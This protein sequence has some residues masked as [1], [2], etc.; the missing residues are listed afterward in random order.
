MIGHPQTRL[1][2]FSISSGVIVERANNARAVELPHDSPEAQSKGNLYL[3]IKLTD[4]ESGHARLY[5]QMLAATQATYYT[6]KGSIEASLVHAI[7]AADVAL[8]EASNQA[9]A[10][11]AGGISAVALVGNDVFIAQAGPAL[12]LV[13]HPRTVEQFPALLTERTIP[14]GGPDRP[15]VEWFQTQVESNSTIV[16]LQSEWTQVAPA[17]RL[18]AATA[19]GDVIGALGN[20]G[21]EAGDTE[22]SALVVTVVRAVPDTVTKPSVALP[23]DEK[24]AAKATAGGTLTRS[25]RQ[26][27]QGAGVRL[28]EGARGFSE[29]LRN[30]KPAPVKAPKRIRK[31]EDGSPRVALYLVILI[32]LLAALI[33][34]AVW[35]QRGQ[36]QTA[37][38]EQLLREAQEG[39]RSALTLPD[40]A[41]QRQLLK[42]VYQKIN[43]AL[44]VRPDSVEAKTLLRE[45][46]FGLDRV[47]R[48]KPLYLLRTLREFREAGRDMSRLI[49]VSDQDIYVLDKGNDWVEHLRL[50]DMR[51]AVTSDPEPVAHKGQQ[52]ANMVVGDLVDMVWVPSGGNRQTAA[53]LIL[54]SAGTLLQLD[55]TW[56]VQTLPIA[57][58]ELWRYPQLTSGFRGNFY[59]LDPQLNQLLRYRPSPEGYTNDPESYFAEGTVVDM[60]GAVDVAIDGSVWIL[61]ANGILQKF[62]DGR[63]EPFQLIGADEPVRAPTSLFV[64][65][66]ESL[67]QHLY[68]ADAGRGRIVEYDKEGNFVRQFRLAEGDELNHIRSFYVNEVDG[69]LYLLTNDSL[70]ITDLPQ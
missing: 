18:A 6:F 54:D 57:Q 4:G 69:Y 52:L 47:N 30:P 1:G 55:P 50:N 40:E 24:P 70:Y 43:E 53:L 7:Q 67:T 63:Q 44:V 46:E 38:Y 11:V 17:E 27:V 66:G 14:L 5:R 65:Q 2:Q 58:R 15:E 51:D 42:D 25:V 22:L 49:V 59:I 62:F 61:Y 36:S 31:R 32:P 56:G 64:G 23:Q 34:A 13:T 39:Q 37:R 28:T 12:T 26:R 16:L 3:L 45:I 48:V 8:R 10:V 35:W 41:L 9:E 29:R 33:V 60:G 19:A 20:L 68:I 21:S